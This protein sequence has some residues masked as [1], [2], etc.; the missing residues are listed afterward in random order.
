MVIESVKSPVGYTTPANK[1]SYAF[2]KKYLHAHNLENNTDDDFPV[3]RYAETL[4]SLAE[5]LN[6][7]NKSAEALLYLNQVRAR[8]GLP[9]SKESDQTK[10]RTIIAH[11]RRMEL[12]FENKRWLDLVRTGKAIETMNDNGIYLKA[13]FNHLLPQ[14][15]KVTQNRLVFAIPQRE[16]LIGGLEQNPGYN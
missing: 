12:A 10:L 16:I 2:I 9:A 11:E 15:Y 13:R 14:S 5:V 6:E 8:A 3:Y 1:R 7:E 4:L